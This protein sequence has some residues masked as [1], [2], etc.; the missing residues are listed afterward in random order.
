MFFAKP[1]QKHVCLLARVKGPIRQQE[2]RI[3]ELLL[4]TELLQSWQSPKSEFVTLAQLF[5]HQ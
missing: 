4:H 1:Q 2:L 3:A 5:M